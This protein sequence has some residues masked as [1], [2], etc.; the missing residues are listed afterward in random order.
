MQNFEVEL[1]SEVRKD[2]FEQRLWLWLWFKLIID[3]YIV[4]ECYYT[5]MH[6]VDDKT[7]T[8]SPMSLVMADHGRLRVYDHEQSHQYVDE[9]FQVY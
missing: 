9:A 8:V 1:S 3:A 2:L 7:D 5:I 6:L 4:M